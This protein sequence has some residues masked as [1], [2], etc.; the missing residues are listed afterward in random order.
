MDERMRILKLL[1]E[2]KITADEAVRL[3]EAL[4]EGKREGEEVGPSLFRM[5][6]SVISDTMRTVPKILMTAFGSGWRGGKGP[7]LRTFDTA[8]IESI[9]MKFTCGDIILEGK[10][11][12]KVEIRGDTGS[13][14]FERDDKE[15]SIEGWGGDFSVSY[16]REKRIVLKLFAGDVRIKGIASK[17]RMDLSAGDVDMDFEEVREAK[18]SIMGGDLSLTFPKRS[19][20][21]I[22]MRGE[23]GDVETPPDVKV[24]RREGFILISNS[25]EPEGEIEISG[26]IG[27]FVLKLRR[28]EDEEG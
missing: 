24:E 4:K 7:F 13:I 23:F 5:V 11:E 1:E 16:P 14:S 27:D 26:Y 12:E 20:F 15:L 2:G 18:V 10:Q 22:L 25:E 19:K 17:T 28:E 9:S 8:G 3:L 6:G 21:R